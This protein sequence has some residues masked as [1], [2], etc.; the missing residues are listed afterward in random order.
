[1]SSNVGKALTAVTLERPRVIT[2]NQDAALLTMIEASVRRRMIRAEMRHSV[3]LLLLSMAHACR[4]AMS[5]SLSIALPDASGGGTC[6]KV[7]LISLFVSS[8][9]HIFGA[10][11]WPSKASSPA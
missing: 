11:R 10:E 7:R 8:R 5:W 2:K 9:E 1:M 4:L 6:L 3:L